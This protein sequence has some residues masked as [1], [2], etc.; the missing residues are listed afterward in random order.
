MALLRVEGLPA[1]AGPLPLS[2]RDIPAESMIE[3]AAIGYPAFDY[4][5]DAGE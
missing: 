4:R 3:V 1:S 2:L 5:N